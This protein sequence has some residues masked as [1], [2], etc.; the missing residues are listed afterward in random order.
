LFTRIAADI[1]ISKEFWTEL[2]TETAELARKHAAREK[3]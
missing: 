3:K 2:K 1:P